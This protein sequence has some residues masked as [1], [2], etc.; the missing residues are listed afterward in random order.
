MEDVADVALLAP[1]TAEEAVLE[2]LGA[3]ADEP[4]ELPDAGG[5]AVPPV[6]QELS[7]V[8]IIISRLLISSTP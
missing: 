2:P 4:A 7:A 6:K 1:E 3:A 5:G 8:D